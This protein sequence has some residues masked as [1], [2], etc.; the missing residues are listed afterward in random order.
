LL[1]KR[2]LPIL[3]ILACV[4]IPFG[5]SLGNQRI[6][7]DHALLEMRLDPSR[8]PGAAELWQENYW[9]YLD[10][11][12]LY[13]P[14]SLTML[15][16]ERLAFGLTEW[17]YRL[18]NLLLYSFCGI[19]CYLFLLRITDRVPALAGALLFALHPAHVEVVVTAY[20]QVEMLA[21]AFLLAAL[22]AH[23]RSA[24]EDSLRWTAI[25]ATAFFA[26]IL[27]KESAVCFPVLAALT[28]GLWMTPGHWMAPR[29]AFYAVVV[30]AYAA[31][32]FAV[33]GS[34]GTPDTAATMV[35]FSLARKLYV[36]ATNGLGNYARL[37][38]FPES[39]SMVYDVFPGPMRDAPWVVAGA[40]FLALSARV[41]GT[42]AVLFAAAWFA[43]TWFIFSN[44][45]IPTG[46]F[47]AERCLFLP[48]FAVC[49][50]F[51]LY[52][53]RACDT[54]DVNRRFV[55]AAGLGLILLLAAAQSA[56][57][58]WN[59]RTEESS[60]RASI[61][62]RPTSPTARAML[63]IN[64][65]VKPARTADELAEA[66]A[67]LQAV[68]QQFP[69]VPEAHRGL[70]LAAKVRGDFK[71][72]VEHL[73]RGLQLRPRDVLIQEDLAICERLAAGSP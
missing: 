45:V 67:M 24:E 59:W 56:R 6:G 32:K 13:R 29:D 2:W 8:V 7:D 42:R 16:A 27:S 53:E 69:G 68:L 46:V 73:Q 64:L 63:A 18:V 61:A 55:R 35:G 28:R 70:G 20:G 62:E 37:S 65:V 3:L 60:L 44:L 41:L 5:V 52:M 50:L 57:T 36:I 34:I 26:A 12:G 31:V 30:A 54:L 25:A 19:L 40:L 66:D 39:Q 48:V 49:F 47:V 9:G 4:W 51:G 72:A 14:L 15:Y 58:A 33:I 71:G 11:S 17:P 1:T 43:A 22:I 38:L 10:E 23:V 21:T